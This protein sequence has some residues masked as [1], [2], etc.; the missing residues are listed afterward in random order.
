VIDIFCLL[1]AIVYS[2]WA[3]YELVPLYK[4]K[5]W[6]ELWTN[7]VAGSFTFTLVVLICID[8][9]IPSPEEP[10]RE[11]ITSIFGK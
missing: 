10:I 7:I 1:A 6:R 8:V 4:Q 9:K 2:I 3:V 11:F 5:Y